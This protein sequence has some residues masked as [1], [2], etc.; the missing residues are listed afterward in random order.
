M[1]ISWREDQFGW[2]RVNPLNSQLRIWELIDPDEEAA[3]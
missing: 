2:M 3:G 1:A